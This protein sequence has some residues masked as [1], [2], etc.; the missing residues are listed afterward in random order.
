M[1]EK[2]SIVKKILGRVK[3]RFNVAAAE[4]DYMDVHDRARLGF[5]SVGL[6]RDVVRNVLERVVDFVED[7]YLAEVVE[8]DFEV[9]SY[10]G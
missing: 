8:E 7:Q 10:G 1:K 3:S 6:D 5:A 4:V 9:E 2:R